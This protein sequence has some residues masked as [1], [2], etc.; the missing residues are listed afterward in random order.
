MSKFD[1]FKVNLT[2]LIRSLELKR[3]DIMADVKAYRE[4]DDIEED[5]DLSNYC[6]ELEEASACLGHAIDHINDAI[7]F[8]EE[9]DE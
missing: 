7:A 1:I 4:D 2:D 5:D 9:A 8:R 3:D 6:D